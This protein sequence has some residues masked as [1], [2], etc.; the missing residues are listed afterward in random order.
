MKKYLKKIYRYIFPRPTRTI[1]KSTFVDDCQIDDFVKVSKQSYLYKSK[2]SSYTYLAGFNNIMN[3]HIGKFCSI[4]DFTAI[5]AGNHPINFISTSPAFYST[6]NQCNTT[7]SDAIYFD[8]MK[9]TIIG[10]DVWIGAFVV[11]MGGVTIGDGAVIAAGSFVNKDVAPYEI[12]GGTPAKFIKKRFS[13][14]E[15]E[16]LLEMKWWNKPKEWLHDNFKKFHDKDVFFT[17][18]FK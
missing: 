11:I 5:G 18:F 12:V 16:K 6:H 9:P 15:V 1:H 7:F 17:E 13:D 3:T 4:G 14:D 2:I 10:N 8:E